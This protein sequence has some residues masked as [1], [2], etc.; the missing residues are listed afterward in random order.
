M[1]LSPGPHGLK[2][3]SW[4]SVTLSLCVLSQG[5]VERFWGHLSLERPWEA[6]ELSWQVRWKECMQG[7]WLE[8][9]FLGWTEGE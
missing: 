8:S 9:P 6:L 4:E 3:N 5:F 1:M 2:G 7:I